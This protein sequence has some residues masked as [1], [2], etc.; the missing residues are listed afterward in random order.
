MKKKDW[1]DTMIMPSSV[2]VD[3]I[4]PQPQHSSTFRDDIRQKQHFCMDYSLDS[5]SL[6]SSI[7][8]GNSD[9]SNSHSLRRS[10]SLSAIVIHSSENGDEQQ[11]LPK[12]VY[13]LRPR[14]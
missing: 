3:T 5:V 6:G 11:T 1:K 7:N 8:S 9:V 13:N 14:I 4:L 2:V 12:R 10:L